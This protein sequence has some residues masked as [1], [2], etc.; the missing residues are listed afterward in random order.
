[1][2][3]KSTRGSD[4]KLLAS[5]TILE[6]LSEDGGLFVPEQIPTINIKE[7]SKL[8]RYQDV[9]FLILKNFLTDYTDDEISYCI[10]RAYNFDKFDSKFVAPI[11]IL[12]KNCSITELWH[13][14]TQAFKD[15]ALQIMPLLLSIAKDKNNVKN[16]IVILVATSGDTGKAALEGYRDVK[17]TKIIVFFPHNGVSEIQ[18]LQMVTQEGTNTFSFAVKGNF[19]DV[20]NSVKSIFNDIILN[21]KLLQNGFELSSAN[22]IN[23]GR[24]VPQIVYYFYSYIQGLKNNLFDINSEINFVVP[25][26]NFGNILAGYYAKKMGLPVKKLICASNSNNV[27]TDF[28]NTGIYNRKR[29]FYK[30]I[31]PSM[32]ILISSN[33]ERLLYD[34]SDSD[35]GYISKLMNQLKE[36]GEYKINNDL[37]SKIKDLFWAD[38]ADDVETKEQIYKD[39]K[40]NNY[41]LDTHTAVGRTVYLKYISQTKDFTP[42]FILSTANPYKFSISI[43]EALFGKPEYDKSEFDL[44]FEIEEKTK[45]LIPAPLRS[46]KEKD[47]I[48]KSI[49][50]KEHMV[51]EIL[52]ILGIKS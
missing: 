42:T 19:D 29:K 5:E 15:I 50:N 51:D 13:G 16:E 45:V 27:L 28:I 32:D 31:S 26:G 30:T 24:L 20:Q 11:F 39:F 3:Y 9:A 36:K 33:L 2:F 44:M 40:E 46:L 41:L 35:A 14:P 23:W 21:K 34:L 6:G 12:N 22:S 47:I 8:E 37:H 1:M 49:I 25:T 10:E 52:K 7:V 38:W 43:Y 48:H 17:G 18:R 4:K